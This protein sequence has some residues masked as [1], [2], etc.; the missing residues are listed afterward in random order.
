MKLMGV[1]HIIHV[2]PLLPLTL[3]YCSYVEAV[4]AGRT[5][6][7]VLHVLLLDLTSTNML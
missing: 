1:D 4:A 7:V 6:Q 5:T 2:I 3:V